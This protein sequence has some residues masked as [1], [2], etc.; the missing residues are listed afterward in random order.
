MELFF[1]GS[2]LLHINSVLLSE[3]LQYGRLV[4]LLA[5]AKFFNDTCSFKFSLKSLQGAF[6]VFALFYGYY[7][8]CF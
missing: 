4:E 3:T 5:G 8:H 6:D 2:K 7:D 1:R